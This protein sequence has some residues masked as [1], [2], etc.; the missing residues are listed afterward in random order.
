MIYIMD[1][2]RKSSAV[3]VIRLDQHG[4]AVSSSGISGS[5][6]QIY[7]MASNTWTFPGLT[8]NG[9][10][11][12]T[13]NLTVTGNISAEGLSTTGSA[14]VGGDLTVTGTIINGGA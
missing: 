2:P 6:T 12:V 9:N 10:L 8:V 13:G 1:S 7:N 4:I 3:N 14:S 5:W 11:N